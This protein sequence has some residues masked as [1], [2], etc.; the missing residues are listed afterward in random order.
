[1]SVKARA[2]LVKRVGMGEGV[3]YGLTWHAGMGSTIATLPI[4]YADG[5]H[6]VLSN[7]MPVLVDG[8][9]AE[10]VGRVC[11]DQLM[12]EVPKGAQA[13]RGSVFTLVGTDG[14]ERITMD[15]MAELAGTINYETACGFGMR[16]ERI[17][18]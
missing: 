17:Y 4:G 10:Q 1:M 12:A 11:M 18:R 5:V 8:R 6:R 9:R 14:D 7:K 13:A 3:S 2:T 15:E 16:L